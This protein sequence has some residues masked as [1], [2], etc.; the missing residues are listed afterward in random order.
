MG[1]TALAPPEDH[2][3][4]EIEYDSDDELPSGGRG[5]LVF[6]GIALAAYIYSLDGELSMAMS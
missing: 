3:D 4:S 1:R 6:L 5:S 2:S